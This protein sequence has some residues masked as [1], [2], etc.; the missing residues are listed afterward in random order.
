M[1]YIFS[2]VLI[3]SFLQPAQARVLQGYFDGR[4]KIQLTKLY[5]FN[6]PVSEY[7]DLMTSL[8]RWGEAIAEGNT[9]LKESLPVISEDVE[10]ETNPSHLKIDSKEPEQSPCSS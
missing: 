2:Q 5:D 9:T 1:R 8:I 7:K 10:N 3:I 4:L 6:I